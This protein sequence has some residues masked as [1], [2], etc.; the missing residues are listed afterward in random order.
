ME[1]YVCLDSLNLAKQI[2]KQLN[3]LSTDTKKPLQS[4]TTRD[5]EFS[6]ETIMSHPMEKVAEQL[7]IIDYDIFS[8]VMV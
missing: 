4:N 6:A 8:H 7:T 2:R 3:K 1:E 5:F